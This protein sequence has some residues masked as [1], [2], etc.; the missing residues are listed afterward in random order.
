[1]RNTK[2]TVLLLV[3]I[4]TVTLATGVLALRT[5]DHTAQRNT[6]ADQMPIVDYAGPDSAAPEE[7]VKRQRSSARYDNSRLVIEPKKPG[8][9]IVVKDHTIGK[10]PALPVTLSDAIV[11]GDVTDAQV[12]LSN[13]KSG[14]Y[15]EFTIRVDEILKDPG[16]SLQIGGPIL[17]HRIGG[18]VRFPSG[19]VQRYAISYL[20][21]PGANRRY[22][23]FLKKNDDSEAFVILTGYEL[24]AGE[25]YPLDGASI[26]GRASVLPQFVPYQ[27]MDETTFLSRVR[28]ASIGS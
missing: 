14:V 28:T 24:R 16:G 22:A 11:I 1:M 2:K 17:A 26:P 5:Q 23:L 25:V 12:H 6:A 9:A 19:L 13:D 20:G 7:R 10:L 8:G 21:M 4:L 18:R 15:T 3:V 27:G